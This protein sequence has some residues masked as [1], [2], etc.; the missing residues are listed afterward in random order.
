MGHWLKTPG[1]QP[2]TKWLGNILLFI[3]WY[4]LQ[5]EFTLKITLLATS[6][7]HMYIHIY[8]WR[9]HPFISVFATPGLDIC[10]LTPLGTLPSSDFTFNLKMLTI[11]SL[12]YRLLFPLLAKSTYASGMNFTTFEQKAAN[13]SFRYLQTFTQKNQAI[14]TSQYN[15]HFTQYLL[16]S[17]VYISHRC[18]STAIAFHY[19]TYSCFHDNCITVIKKN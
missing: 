15:Q 14:V 16:H 18:N 11:L 3:F 19:L 4:F 5:T 6:P 17:P 13:G 8:I 2:S 7:T 1:I 12:T 9:Y 10:S